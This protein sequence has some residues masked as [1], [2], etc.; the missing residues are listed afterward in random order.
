MVAFG[1]GAEVMFDASA[2]Q[3]ARPSPLFWSFSPVAIEAGEE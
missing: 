2:A 1:S 3:F